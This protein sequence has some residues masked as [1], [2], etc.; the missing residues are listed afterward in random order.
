MNSILTVTTKIYRLYLCDFLVWSIFT[1]NINFTHINI[2]FF[3]ESLKVPSTS[4]NT[5]FCDSVITAGQPLS[6]NALKVMDLWLVPLIT[7]TSEIWNTI[8]FWWTRTALSSKLELNKSDPVNA[9]AARSY[10]GCRPHSRAREH[11]GTEE[12][13]VIDTQHYTGWRV[14]CFWRLFPAGPNMFFFCQRHP[15]FAH[16]SPPTLAEYH[17]F[18]L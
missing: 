1:Y 12:A 4:L 14:S 8:F 3:S 17:F 15:A 18:L 10:D 13:G 7:Q 9:S 11:G 2:S 16:L 6:K 5:N